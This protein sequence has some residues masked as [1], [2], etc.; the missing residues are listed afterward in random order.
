MYFTERDIDRILENLDGLRERVF[1]RLHG[2]D[3]LD[4]RHAQHFPSVCL[5]GLGRCGSNIALDVAS[6]VYNARRFYLNEFSSQEKNGE[7]RP[8][9]WIRSNLRLSS[10]RGAKP[11]FLIEPLVM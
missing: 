3:G 10:G 2:D 9:S 11:V 1:P 4:A 5:I 7:Q 8:A 6:L